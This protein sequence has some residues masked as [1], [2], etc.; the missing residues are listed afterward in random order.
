M[1]RDLM[2][3][4]DKEA[5]HP[6][7]SSHNW[8]FFRDNDDFE[9]S[10]DKLINALDTNLDHVR[11][12]T[13]LLVRALEWQSSGG[14]LLSD[15]EITRAET[16]L[17]TGMNLQPEPTDLHTQYIFASRKAAIRRQRRILAGVTIALVVAIGL[18]IA[19]FFL[20]QLSEV[21]RVEAEQAQCLA[22]VRGN[23]VRSLALA[24]NA[25]NLIN[26]AENSLGLALAISA[27]E[28]YDPPRADV[29]QTLADAI[30]GPNARYRMSGHSKS[31][32][33]VAYSPDGS[34]GYSVPPDGKL[35]MWNL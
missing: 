22:E 5:L 19:S 27:Y 1:Y 12:H 14:G 10:F 11:E 23:E 2:D 13:R 8:I 18:A 4:A 25:R 33:D 35:I 3:K 32:L 31:V 26:D 16:W 9:Q 20:F 17:G 15:T 6:I 24:A 29:Q 7:I 34:T 28:A 21:R 30:Y